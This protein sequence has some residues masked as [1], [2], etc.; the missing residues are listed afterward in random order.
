MGVFERFLSAWVALAI[1]GTDV[2]H[3]CYY[4]YY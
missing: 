4:L 2:R 3:F 1:I